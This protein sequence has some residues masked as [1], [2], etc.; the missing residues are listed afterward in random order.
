M[1]SNIEFGQSAGTARSTGLVEISFLSLSLESMTCFYS[2]AAI[3]EELTDRLNL[4]NS[5]STPTKNSE[6]DFE[7]EPVDTDPVEYYPNIDG[8][9]ITTKCNWSSVVINKM[10]R[11]SLSDYEIIIG[12][13]SELQR[14]A[15]PSPPMQLAPGSTFM[16][17]V[18]VNQPASAPQ[19]SAQNSAASEGPQILNGNF[20]KLNDPSSYVYT[21]EADGGIKFDGIIYANGIMLTA[22]ELGHEF[23]TQVSALLPAPSVVASSSAAQAVESATVDQPNILNDDQPKIYDVYTVDVDGDLEFVGKENANGQRCYTDEEDTLSK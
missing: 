18:V 7:S 5:T 4:N 17:Y 21:I 14:I 22:Q 19:L 23:S 20:S 13:I 15:S 1:D 8:K 12:E 9:R 2:L 16:E 10:F 11:S 6:I 3:K